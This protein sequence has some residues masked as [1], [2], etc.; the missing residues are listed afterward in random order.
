M[1]TASV[2]LL[3]SDTVKLKVDAFSFLFWDTLLILADGK[4]GVGVSSLP[5][6]LQ[7]ATQDRIMAANMNR[8]MERWI[9]FTWQVLVNLSV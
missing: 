2:A 7:D 5:S 6:L 9:M 8:C 1:V 4:A 3:L